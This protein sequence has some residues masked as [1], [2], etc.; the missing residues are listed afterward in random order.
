[1][2]VRDSESL[3]TIRPEASKSTGVTSVLTLSASNEFP[4]LSLRAL[5]KLEAPG[6]RV[7]GSSGRLRL[8]VNDF[9]ASVGSSTCLR[10]PMVKQVM[11]CF[12]AILQTH[13]EKALRVLTR[14]FCVLFEFSVLFRLILLSNPPF[15]VRGWQP[16]FTLP[17]SPRTK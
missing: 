7:V 3:L 4:D 2:I 5:S 8:P 16:T 11:A 13:W 6:W 17:P 10:F 1:M 14:V 12:L 15:Q 9:E